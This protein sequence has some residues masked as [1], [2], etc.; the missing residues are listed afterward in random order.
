MPLTFNFIIHSGNWQEEVPEAE[1]LSARI[2]KAISELVDVPEAEL[3]VVLADD[4]YIQF[5]NNKFRK[6][7]KPTN[8]L[9]FPTDEEGEVGDVILSLNTLK[10]EALEQGKTLTNHFIHLLTHGILHLLGFDHEQEDEA[11]EME[12]LEIIILNTL[13]VENPYKDDYSC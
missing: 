8:V 7:D 3:S 2:T 5:L 1:F 12:N 13:N 4:E 10:K 6:K 11:E 9:S